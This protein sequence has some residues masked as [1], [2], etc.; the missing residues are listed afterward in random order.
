MSVCPNR[1]FISNKSCTVC[2]GH[3]KEGAPCNKLTGLC[4]N[5]CANHW[6]GSF[7]NCMY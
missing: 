1:T 2:P 4:D 6:N 3:C 7:C 5:G